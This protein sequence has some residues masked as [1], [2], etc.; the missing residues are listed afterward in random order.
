MRIT[1]KDFLQL[2]EFTL[3]DQP[4]K[5]TQQNRMVVWVQY[6]GCSTCS[7]EYPYLHS[8]LSRSVETYAT[9]LKLIF[10]FWVLV[11]L[12]VK[13]VFARS[14]SC[15]N[16]F[17]FHLHF[18]ANQTFFHLKSFARR[19]VLTQ[20]QTTT[21]K[22]DVTYRNLPLQTSPSASLRVPEKLI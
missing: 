2:V 10:R 17:H 14:C 15:E 20:R 3:S 22:W 7:I 12:C 8:I 6:E 5:L 16:V 13:R 19:L 21:R 18:H 4:F 1:T 9:T 11:C